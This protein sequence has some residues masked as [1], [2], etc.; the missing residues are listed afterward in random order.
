M[1]LNNIDTVYRAGR[2]LP[3]DRMK[4]TVG[5]FIVERGLFSEEGKSIP[6]IFKEELRSMIRN[7]EDIG[8]DV[9]RVTVV[10]DFFQNNVHMIT[11]RWNACIID[12]IG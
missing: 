5:P 2:V 12:E 6:E 1:T 8:L 9:G 11:G 3:L 4:M 10:A 7:C